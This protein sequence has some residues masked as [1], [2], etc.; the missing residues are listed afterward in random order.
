MEVKRLLL[1][2]ETHCFQGIEDTNPENLNNLPQRTS[3]T[4]KSAIEKPTFK[5]FLLD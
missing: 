2:L 1:E 4:L 5:Q 3:F